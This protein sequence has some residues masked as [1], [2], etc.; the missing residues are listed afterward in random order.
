MQV[1]RRRPDACQRPRLVRTDHLREIERAKAVVLV[2]FFLREVEI[3]VRLLADHRAEIA[4]RGADRELLRIDV[5]QLAR[6]PSVEPGE[7]G[8]ESFHSLR[9]VFGLGQG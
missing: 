6:V 9:V 7:P 5:R 8:L 3:A 2:P 1:R 4:Q